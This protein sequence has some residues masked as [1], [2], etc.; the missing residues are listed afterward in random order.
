MAPIRNGDKYANFSLDEESSLNPIWMAITEQCHHIYD[1]HHKA[2]IGLL[3]VQK[4]HKRGKSKKER[5]V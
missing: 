2:F 3:P 4:V 5:D 1:D